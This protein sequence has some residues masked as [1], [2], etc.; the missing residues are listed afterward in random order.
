MTPTVYSGRLIYD[1]D[2]EIG[3]GA[4]VLDAGVGSGKRFNISHYAYSSRVR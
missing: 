1:E 2:V 3:E 4:R